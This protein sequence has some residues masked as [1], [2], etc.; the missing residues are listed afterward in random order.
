MGGFWLCFTCFIGGWGWGIGIEC[1]M[2]WNVKVKEGEG[3]RKGCER[4]YEMSDERRLCCWVVGCIYT[5]T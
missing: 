3:G 4:I 2:E 5:S 1:M